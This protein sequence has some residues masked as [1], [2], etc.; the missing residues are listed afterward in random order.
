MTERIARFEQIR[1][2]MFWTIYDIESGKFIR[3]QGYDDAYWWQ[4]V[5]KSDQFRIRGRYRLDPITNKV[6]ILGDEE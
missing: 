4:N 6:F 5:S 2:D 1:N 3:W